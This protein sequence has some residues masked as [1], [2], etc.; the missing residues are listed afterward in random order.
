MFNVVKFPIQDGRTYERMGVATGEMYRMFDK[1]KNTD[2]A[3]E[4]GASNSSYREYSVSGVISFISF[5]LSS[6]PLT[7]CTLYFFFSFHVQLS[8]FLRSSNGFRLPKSSETPLILIGPGTGVA[9]FVGFLAHREELLKSNPNLPCGPIWLF[10][11]CRSRDQDYLFKYVLLSLSI[12][13]MLQFFFLFSFPSC[14][15]RLETS[16]RGGIH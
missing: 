2:S 3:S 6:S 13:V 12:Y 8:V 16:W 7:I 15:T 11:G 14:V 4:S 9:P 5:T 1:M 10:Y